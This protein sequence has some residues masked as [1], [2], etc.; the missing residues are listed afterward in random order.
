MK[1]LGIDTST[2]T[3]SI[4]LIEDDK[5][6]GELNFY[7]N[8]DHSE[9]LIANIGFLLAGNDLTIKDLDLIGVAIGPGSFTGIRIGIATVMG[10][11]EFSNLPVVPVSSLEI[12]SRNFSSQKHVALAIDAKRDRVYGGIYSYENGQG[13]KISEDLYNIDDF[14][15]K[16]SSYQDIVLAGDINDQLKE[17]LGENLSL[18]YDT[19]LINR[20]SNLCFIAKRDY[21]EGKAIS[22]QDL[23][24][25]Y[26]TKSQAQ[27]D[28]EKKHGK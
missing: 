1:I 4:A 23:R 18:A 8:M 24:A 9:R 16:I 13:F 11:C 7:S 25:N 17:R 22:H 6:L 19:N 3:M 10:L 26:M 21:E 5:I 20:A 28:F 27:I 12:L 2:R 15:Q 14:L